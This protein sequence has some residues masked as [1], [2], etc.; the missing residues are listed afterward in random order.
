MFSLPICVIMERV[1][2]M[3]HGKRIT[4]KKTNKAK[5]F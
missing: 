1:M 5:K 4:E 2:K 3:D